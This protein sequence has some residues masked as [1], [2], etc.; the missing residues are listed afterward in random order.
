MKNSDVKWGYPRHGRHI[1]SFEQENNVPTIFSQEIP[2][3]LS[4][5]LNFYL[6]QVR[7]T[8]TDTSHNLKL[9]LAYILLYQLDSLYVVYCAYKM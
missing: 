6:F 5:N 4:V 3:S 9:E 2:H 8:S 1:E 7:P